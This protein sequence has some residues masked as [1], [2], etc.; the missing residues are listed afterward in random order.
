MLRCLCLLIACTQV[1]DRVLGISTFFLNQNAQKHINFS[2]LVNYMNNIMKYYR[3]ALLIYPIKKLFTYNEY[4]LLWPKYYEWTNILPMQSP[5]NYLI[6]SLMIYMY[7]VYT[8]NGI[9]VTRKISRA[10][11]V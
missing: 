3:Y 4:F 9:C 1:S 10:C 5:L 11:F 2:Y 6:F 7:L 8:R